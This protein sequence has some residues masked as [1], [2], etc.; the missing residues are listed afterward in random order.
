MRN[1]ITLDGKRISLS[2]KNFVSKLTSHLE[3]KA[4]MQKIVHRS[5][6]VDVRGS[7]GHDVMDVIDQIP[8][9]LVADLFTRTYLHYFQLY[10][11]HKEDAA[12]NQAGNRL[13]Q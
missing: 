5:A 13:C 4:V 1:S 8:L 10:M 3:A 9:R 2:Q 6:D 11:F 7:I 12:R